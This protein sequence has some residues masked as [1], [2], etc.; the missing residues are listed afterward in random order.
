MPDGPRQDQPL[1]HPARVG[2]SSAA[3]LSAHNSPEKGTKGKPF[4]STRAYIARFCWSRRAAAAPAVVAAAGKVLM[5]KGWKT[6]L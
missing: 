2:V 5:D 3:A 6:E 4:G 1:G